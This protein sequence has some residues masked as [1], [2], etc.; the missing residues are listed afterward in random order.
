MG[1]SMKPWES[2]HARL[3]EGWET[4]WK[5]LIG[6]PRFEA[7]MERQGAELDELKEPL[8]LELK[9]PA[10]RSHIKARQQSE[11]VRQAERAA[12]ERHERLRLKLLQ[13]ILSCRELIV[14]EGAQSNASSR[15]VAQ[16]ELAA[17]QKEAEIEAL[18]AAVNHQREARALPRN[19][20]APPRCARQR[21]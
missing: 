6:S 20:T 17:Q 12:A 7:A 18:A 1:T 5:E 21:R 16:A 4:S 8:S 9:V 11:Q 2:K 15:A 10:E 19:Q 14:Q 13:N 3:A